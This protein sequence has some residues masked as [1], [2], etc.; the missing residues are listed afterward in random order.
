MAVPLVIGN[1]VKA[2]AK[3]FQLPTPLCFL[4]DTFVSSG[5]IFL[6]CTDYKE[7]SL[8][9]ALHLALS[10]VCHSHLIVLPFSL[11]Q[12]CF[13]PFQEPTLLSFLSLNL[14]D[15]FVLP[16]F[17]NLSNIEDKKKDLA[18]AE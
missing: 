16:A 2:F 11:S 1:I 3:P 15:E 7:G 10:L 5:Q 13:T 17:L 8:L 6:V 12:F 9:T 4:I 18:T 14:L